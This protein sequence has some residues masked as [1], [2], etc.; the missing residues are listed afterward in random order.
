LNPPRPPLSWE[1]VVE[2]TF[3]SDFDLL[4]DTRQ[5]IRKRAWATPAG[6]LAMDGYFKLLRAKEEILRLNVEI[7]RL[8]TYMRDEEGY[9]QVKE[10]EV[11][12]ANPALAHQILLH[13]MEKSRYIE[14]HM[15]VLNNIT[16]LKGYSGGPLLGTRRMSKATGP[17]QTD[18]TSSSSAA[19][20]PGGVTPVPEEMEE[21]FSLE[22]EHDEDLEEEQAGEDEDTEILGAF[23]NVFELSLDSHP[24]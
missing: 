11:Q 22:A 2:Y 13:R 14:H 5:D 20:V 17:L 7:P 9:L 10:D 16:S 6:R 1:E 19:P 23:F 24:N 3:I 15:A 18:Q 8:A 21:D 4:R 12:S